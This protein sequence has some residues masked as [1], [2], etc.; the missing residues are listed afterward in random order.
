MLTPTRAFNPH[1]VLN[2][3]SDGLVV[4]AKDGEVIALA[5]SDQLEKQRYGSFCVRSDGYTPH[6]PPP[7]PILLV[8]R[9]RM[10]SPTAAEQ[11]IILPS[12]DALFQ[13]A[14]EAL[15]DHPSVCVWGV[16]VV[17]LGM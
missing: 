11:D 13:E 1:T 17:V 7:L 5:E 3:D 15:A 6:I 8:T 9:R 2:N 12:M 4:V 14:R 10:P 16:V